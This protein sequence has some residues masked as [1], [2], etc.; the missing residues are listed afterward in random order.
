MSAVASAQENQPLAPG[1]WRFIDS[2]FSSA[3]SNM[4]FDEELFNSFENGKLESV[5]RIY[6]W[7]PKAVSA[8]FSQNINDIADTEKCRED[9]VDAV[10]R[11][12][13]GGALFHSGEITYSMVFSDAL[14][15]TM[16]A[17]ETYGATTAFLIHFYKALGLDA[18]YWGENF[19]SEKIDGSGFCLE[20]RE[21]YDIVIDGKKIGGSAQKR[22]RGVIFQHGSIPLDLSFRDAGRYIRGD[23]AN[24]LAG[25]ASLSGLGVQLSFD[26]AKKILKKS[27]ETVYGVNFSETGAGAALDS[28]IVPGRLPEWLNKKIDFR[29]LTPMKKLLSSYKLH[30]ICVESLC[31]NISECFSRGRATFMILGDVC[32]RGC[33]F[34][35]VGRGG[36]VPHP[37]DEDEA[38]RVAGAAAR[39][40]LKHVVVTS[41]TRD[42][43]RDGGAELF[44]QTVREL[45]KIS[46]P[47][48]IELLIPDFAGDEKS[49]LK[50]LET[51]P[52]IIGHNMETVRDIYHIRK[53]ADYN[54]SLAVLKKIAE[55]RIKAKSGFMLGLGE[56]ESEV[57][58]LIKDIR[59]SGGVYLSIGQYLMPSKSS[60][61]VKRYALPAEFEYYKSAAYKEGFEHVESGPYVR[62]SYMAENY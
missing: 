16:T 21:K 12:T 50:V 51:S 14:F 15:K 18:S 19:S 9:G 38:A 60:Y 47:L 29:S 48:K 53:G 13:G 59:Q 45:R 30:T 42:D 41:P 17:G 62:S 22:R 2:G 58:E 6:G 33:L 5:F 46:P 34:C 24:A 56:T 28:R 52:D 31:P 25:S 37:S 20:G 40:R 23:V 39:L 57:I 61:P 7:E 32:T 35:G 49:L 4:A 27:F 11:M 36:P 8:G 1:E 55:T 26:E 3:Q 44:A 43:L 10:K 54:R